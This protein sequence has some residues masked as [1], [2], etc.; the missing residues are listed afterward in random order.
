M[1]AYDEF[2][3]HL[4]ERARLLHEHEMRLRARARAREAAG[5]RT[6]PPPSARR[7][8]WPRILRRVLRI[9]REYTGLRGARTTPH[10]A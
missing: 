1:T 8:A 9:A 3:L 4:A 5:A 7:E 6:D 10:D 2:H